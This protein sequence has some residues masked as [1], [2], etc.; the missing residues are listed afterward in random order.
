VVGLG[1]QL[2]DRVVG[3]RVDLHEATA[4]PNACHRRCRG[5]GALAPPSRDAVVE[6]MRALR[7][8]VVWI[9]PR[10]CRDA[11]GASRCCAARATKLTPRAARA[12][13]DLEHE[14]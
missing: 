2:G 3:L 9:D 14:L 7:S 12:S 10:R 11:R 4:M 13:V 6:A 5:S 1:K 8:D